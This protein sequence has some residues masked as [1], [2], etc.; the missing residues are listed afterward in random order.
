[1]PAEYHDD[2]ASIELSDLPP[3]PLLR[4][5][6]TTLPLQAPRI[7]AGERK[8]FRQLFT[9]LRWVNTSFYIACKDVLQA[10]YIPTYTSMIR[11]PYAS[12]PCLASW[13]EP[14]QREA[15][16]LNLFIALMVHEEV[17]LGESSLHVE[18]ENL[19]KDLFD[20]QQPR[21]RLEDLV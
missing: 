15:R 20:L 9:Q 21:S 6:Y 18:R 1:F 11:H 3:H 12:D 14:L 4:I 2:Q 17:M 19:F 10:A 5:V 8:T 7:D 16:V 13:G